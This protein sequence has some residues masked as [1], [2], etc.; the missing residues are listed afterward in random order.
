[1]LGGQIVDLPGYH[2]IFLK[3]SYVFY[4]QLISI[5]TRGKDK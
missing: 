3:L 5:C 1:M 4:H 2:M